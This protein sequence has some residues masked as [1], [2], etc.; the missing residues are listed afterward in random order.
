[1]NEDPKKYI[2]KNFNF[3]RDEGFLFKE[4]VRKSTVDGGLDTVQYIFIKNIIKIRISFYRF[5]SCNE[6]DITVSK[7]N[8]DSFFSF[9]EYIISKSYQDY[10]SQEKE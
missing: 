9:D 8:K 10:F 3:L 7:L 2:L 6:L 1:M 5:E 4:E